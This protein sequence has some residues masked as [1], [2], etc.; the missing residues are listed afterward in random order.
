M[1]EMT[2]YQPGT[3]AWVDLMTT[4]PEGARA[5][6]GE[7]FGW[8]FDP[9]ALEDSY[10]MCRIR[11]LEVAGLNGSPAPEGM[12]TAWATYMATDDSDAL[13]QRITDEG[14][15]VM[16]GPDDVGDFGR[17]IVATDSTG[18]LFGSWEARQHIGARLVNEPGTVVWNELLASDLGIAQTFYAACFGYEWEDYDTGEG[19]PAYRLMN[20]GGRS[21]GGAMEITSDMPEETSSHWMT[22][23]AVADVDQTVALAEKLGGTVQVPVMDSP[24]GRFAVLRDPQAGVFSVIEAPAES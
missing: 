16:M 3:P 21:V 12:A 5:F 15:T 17:L 9:G 23:F 8:E 10:L 4:D 13:A 22:Y 24:Q 7:L 14:G 1:V 11:G 6:Y 20:V 2:Q 19:G 18:A